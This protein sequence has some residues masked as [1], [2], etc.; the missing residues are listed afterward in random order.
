MRSI[1]LPVLL[2]ATLAYT[3]SADD[4]PVFKVSLSTPLCSPTSFL[5]RYPK[6]TEIKAPFVEQFTEGW[7]DRWTPSEATKK[8]PVG[9]ETFSY[10]GKWSVEEASA[11]VI[12]GDH[13]LVAKSVASHHA[14]SAPFN[15]AIDISNKPFVVQYEVKYQKGGNCGGGYLKLLEDGFQTSGKE[16]SDNT[17]WVIMFGP[18]LTCPG[19][20]VRFL[21]VSWP[22]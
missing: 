21:Y 16:F 11:S 2:A 20:K 4:K 8:T 5:T 9:G 22:T 3:A 6:S 14:I 15:T 19:T 7:E 1:A 10:V 18:D 17:P 13:G 12:E